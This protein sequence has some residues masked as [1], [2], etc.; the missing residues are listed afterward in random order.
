[1][2]KLSNTVTE[3]KKSIPY[4]KSMYFTIDLVCDLFSYKKMIRQPFL[5]DTTILIFSRNTKN[6]TWSEF[7]TI[8]E[9]SK[10]KRTQ[11]TTQLV[12]N[13]FKLKTDSDFITKLKRQQI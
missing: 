4:K 2:K 13:F 6:C 10:I 7:Y 12:I 9:G 3:L 5:G 11:Q 8:D 1:M